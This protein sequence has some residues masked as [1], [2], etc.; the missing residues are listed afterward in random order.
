MLNYSIKKYWSRL[1][2]NR[3]HSNRFGDG[4][5]NICFEF[6]CWPFVYLIDFMQFRTVFR[7]IFHANILQCHIENAML[8]I[9]LIEMQ[10][11]IDSMTLMPCPLCDYF[12]L[13]WFVYLT[14]SCNTIS[15]LNWQILYAISHAIP[16]LEW[17]D[18]SIWCNSCHK[19]SS[20]VYICLFW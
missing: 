15:L 20:T 1:M 2:M 5:L 19:H 3:F 12:M 10:C 11:T 6:I 8:I 14:I 17:I 7:V 4:Y 9:D 18:N 13:F 16:F